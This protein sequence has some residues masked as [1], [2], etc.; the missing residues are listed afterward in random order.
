M[1]VVTIGMLGCGNIGCGVL[2][3]LN[4]FSADMRHRQGIQFFVKK[5][6]VSQLGKKRPDIV[7]PDRLT[8][9][10]EDVTDDSE[11]E[12]IIECMGG[13]K[14]ATDLM[15]RALKNGKTVVT[16]N[17]M[18][19]ALNWHLLDQAAK[20]GK[21]GLYFEAAV[22]GAM[23]IIRMLSDSLQANHTDR[24]TAIIN[25]TTN[26]ILT[27]MADEGLEY[28]QALS[29][30]QRLGFAEPDPA[31]DVDGEDAV[32]KLSVLASL[33]FHARVP[34]CCVQR[35]GM[36]TVA[37]YDIEAAKNLGYAI[38]LLA[39]AS[40]DGSTVDTHVSPTLIPL[41]HPLA[42][43]K[44]PFNAVYLHG[45]SYGDMMIYG[46]GAGSAPTAS[47]IMGDVLYAIERGKPEYPTFENLTDSLSPAL[48]VAQDRNCAFYLRL[49]AKDTPGVLAH[50]TGCLSKAGVSVRA[51]LQPEARKTGCAQITILT[52]PTF[53]KDMRKAA[54]EFDTRYVTLMNLFRVEE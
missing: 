32:Y 43:V 16:A 11:I 26:Y 20:K 50:V 2:K 41:T 29:E 45:D 7:P 1:R 39:I 22:G 25:G 35:E 3:L 42:S 47:A 27:R 34:V 23:P 53:E 24:L 21:A 5:I 14:P 51:I 54:D 9:R 33:A 49:S 6:L 19:L 12:L 44:G 28:S 48:H 30:A 8:A 18:A 15:V 4:D 36:T 17:K 13:E 37:R 10:P 46:R 52:H 38:R 40:R 31:A